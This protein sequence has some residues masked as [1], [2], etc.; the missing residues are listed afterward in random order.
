MTLLDK[1]LKNKGTVS[2]ALGKK[3]AA[4]ALGGKKTVLTE[5]V[6]LVRYK[7]DEK[8]ARSVRAGAAKVVELVAE[9]R[10]EWVAPH[11]KAL[12]PALE[13][14]EPQTRWMVIR[15][16]GHCAHLDPKTAVKAMPHARR[17][18]GEGEGVCL[19]GATDHYLGA[20]G[21]LS[22]PLA[23]KVFPVLDK[24]TRTAS[25]NEVDWLLEAFMRIYPNLGEKERRKVLKYARAQ[26]G[27]PKKAT[28]KRAARL[29]KMGD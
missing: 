16:F 18:L 9:K 26:K 21:G 25:V 11:L 2:S 8:G 13:L 6:K 28:R 20:V 3:L 14:P 1:L 15:A 22:G 23:A 29:L 19:T 10:P 27:A 7:E 24:A 4:E 5:A 12:L 17:Y